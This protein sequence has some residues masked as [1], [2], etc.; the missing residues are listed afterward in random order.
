[1]NGPIPSMVYP[2][3]NGTIPIPIKFLIKMPPNHHILPVIRHPMVGSLIEISD[4]KLEMKPFGI[5][6]KEANAQAVSSVQYDFESLL[7]GITKNIEDEEERET[8]QSLWF[9]V[10]MEA[11]FNNEA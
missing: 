1:M 2:P 3:M 10:F 8:F 4:R 9:I 5:P 11:I 7:N 6:T